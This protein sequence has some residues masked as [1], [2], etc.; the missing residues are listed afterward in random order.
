MKENIT[1]LASIL[2][3]SILAD[4]E[5]GDQ[6]T[7]LIE[8]LEHDTE[9]PGLAAAIKQVVSM[10]HLFSDD[11]LTDL[12]FNSASKFKAEDKPK[13]FEAAISTILADGVISEDEIANILTVAEALEIPTEK[14]VARLLFQVQ[15]K[16]GECVV[17]VEDIL[18]D[19]FI[20]GGKT[21]YTSWNSFEKMLLEANFP[22]NLIEVLKSVQNWTENTFQENATINYTPNF[23]TL[24]CANPASRS[25]TF[26]FVRMKPNCIRFEYMGNVSDVTSVGDFSQTVKNGITE[27]FNQL[28]KNKI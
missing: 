20:V 17:D 2:A 10:A 16:E 28:S 14:A 4:G 18:E 12:L 22:T 23:M 19:F 6:E 26:C 25:K 7:K 11:Q 15:E 13:V 24:A 21:R 9:L 3:V 1:D 27:Y 8:D 5:V